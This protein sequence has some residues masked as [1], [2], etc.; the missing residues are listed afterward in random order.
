M[1]AKKVLVSWQSLGEP[2]WLPSLEE[3]KNYT[4]KSKFL[5]GGSS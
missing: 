3:G 2:E 5:M 4:Q 1:A